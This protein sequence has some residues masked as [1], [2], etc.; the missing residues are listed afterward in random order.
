MICRCPVCGEYCSGTKNSI[1]SAGINTMNK[2]TD[3]IEDLKKQI[4]S[5][6]PLIQGIGKAIINS[7]STM[8]SW[9]TYYKFECGGCGNK[10]AKKESDVVDETEQ[11]YLAR[12]NFFVKQSGERFLTINPD[13]N[14]VYPMDSSL[15][16]LRSVPEGV[17]LPDNKFEKGEIYISHPADN[18]IFFPATSYRYDVMKDELDDIIVFLQKL[19]AKTICIQGVEQIETKSGIQSLIKTAFGV[20][21]GERS[22]G[23]SNSSTTSDSTFNKLSRMYSKEIK[24]EL[25]H[26][27]EIDNILLS[28]WGT[29][30]KEWNAIPQMREHGILEYNLEIMC[31]SISSNNNIHVDKVEAEYRELCVKT[32]ASVNR[33][34]IKSLRNEAHLGFIIHVKFYPMSEYERF[35]SPKD[36]NP[37]LLRKLFNI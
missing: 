24:S 16:L 10:W 3:G 17:I 27:P 30:R 22:G 33:E 28:K 31:S 25:L 35:K 29:I 4:I 13:A 8:L 19:G 11:Y 32:S 26:L 23:V 12:E 2:I 37:S 20:S 18:S 15:T 7:A 21:A 6:A 1:S 14:C 5:S 34:T 9:D 36:K